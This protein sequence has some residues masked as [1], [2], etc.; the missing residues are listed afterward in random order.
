MHP[1]V[2]KEFERLCQD[3]NIKGAILEIGAV[4][5]NQTLLTLHAL[6][7]AKKKVGINIL[8]PSEYADFNI[9][10]CNS[11]DMGIFENDSFD[12]V[13]CN[14]TLE[15]DKFFWKTIDEIRRVTKP[16]GHVL[17]GVPGYL[18]IKAEKKAQKLRKL[19]F[20]NRFKG[21]SILRLLFTSTFTL[22]IHNYPGDY[23]RFSPQTMQDVFFQNMEEVEIVSVLLPPR[24]I[25]V[26]R[27]KP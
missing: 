5:N 19:P 24:L 22:H 10:Q 1:R 18:Q 26:G 21:H 17:I 8:E 3:R 9:L 11:N 4:P 27:K 6:K 23:Y 20:I 12:A 7:G 15:H 25:G 16:G 13:L 14:A 2:F